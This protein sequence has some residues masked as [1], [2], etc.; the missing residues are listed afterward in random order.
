MTRKEDEPRVLIF[1]DSQERIQHVVV[2]MDGIVFGNVLFQAA[3]IDQVSIA[4]LDE[5]LPLGWSWTTPSLKSIDVEGLLGFA[6]HV[7]ANAGGSGSKRQPTRGSVYSE[8][9]SPSDSD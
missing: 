9:C 1:V 8:F 6:E 2:D 3:T 4:G 7:I 5:A